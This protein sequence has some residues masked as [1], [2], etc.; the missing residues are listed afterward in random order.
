MYVCLCK[1]VTDGDIRAAVENEGAA[2]MRD[3]RRQLGVATCCGCCAPCAREVLAVALQEREQ[4]FA[5][6]VLPA[7][8]PALQPG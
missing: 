6:D 3:L 2:S 5:D 8:N 1:Q 4:A 7:A